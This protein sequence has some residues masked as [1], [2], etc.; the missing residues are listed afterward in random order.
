MK[1]SRKGGGLSSR[2]RAREFEL[3]RKDLLRRRRILLL[4]TLNGAQRLCDAVLPADPLDQA[5]DM[6]EEAFDQILKD[7]SYAKLRE[8][9]RAL[10][11]MSHVSYGT[12]QS[13]HQE[14]PL[15]RLKV[16]PEALHCV[17]C[18]GRKE[19]RSYA[20]PSMMRNVL[21]HPTD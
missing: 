2:I 6:Q 7:R 15:Q 3:L 12:C 18:K 10:Q 11:R 14:I 20:F 9:D 5:A 8:I 21:V 1:S 16:Q 13:C 19:S 4:Q 17:D